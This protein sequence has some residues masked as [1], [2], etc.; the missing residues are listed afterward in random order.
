MR[1][2][3]V[4]SSS[5][6]YYDFTVERVMFTLTSY[7]LGWGDIVADSPLLCWVGCLDKYVLSSL[8]LHPT[9]AVKV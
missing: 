1:S 4:K 5:R 6:V 8:V 9:Q 7:Q 3:F 2:S